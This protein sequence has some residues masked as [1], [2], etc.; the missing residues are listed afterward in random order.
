[1]KKSLQGGLKVKFTIHVK[2]PYIL[3]MYEEISSRGSSG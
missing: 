2:H 3:N 1:M